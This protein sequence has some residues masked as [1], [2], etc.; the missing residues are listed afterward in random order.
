MAKSLEATIL[1]NDS[2]YNILALQGR[3]NKIKKNDIVYNLGCHIEHQIWEM[4]LFLN[5]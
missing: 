4:D 3:A 2:H 5:I 1:Y